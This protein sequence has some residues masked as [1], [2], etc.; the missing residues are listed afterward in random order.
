LIEKNIPTEGESLNNEDH[1]KS[2]Q[3]TRAR[4]VEKELL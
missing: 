2:R 3:V 4:L 1:Q